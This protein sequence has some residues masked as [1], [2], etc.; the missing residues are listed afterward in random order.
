MS[1][2]AGIEDHPLHGHYPCRTPVWWA[3]TSTVGKDPGLRG[4]SGRKIVIRIAK[5]FGRIEGLVAALLRAPRE[6]RRPLDEMNSML[7]ELADG[8][9]TFG[10]ICQ[11]MD[12]LYHEEI[13]PVIQRTAKAVGLFQRNNLMLLL[14]EPLNNRW[15]VGPGKVPDHQMLEENSD[16]D[17][18]P[19]SDE[20]P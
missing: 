5:T 10:E 6:L 2:L 12:G 13:A 20:T 18:I 19:L 16:Y 1:E 7:W 15:F 8:S 3:R 9:R 11:I 17:T 4:V 14:E